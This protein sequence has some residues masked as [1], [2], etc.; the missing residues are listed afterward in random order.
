MPLSAPIHS[1][2]RKARLLSRAD[3]IP[4]SQALNH[5]AEKEGFGS[6]SLLLARRPAVA[7]APAGAVFADLVPGDLLL[8]GARPGQGKTLMSLRLM[9]EAVRAGRRA[10]FFTLEYTGED[11]I[12]RL[13]AIGA[14]WTQFDGLFEFDNSDGINADYIIARLES[15]PRG[16]LVVIDYLQILDQRRDSPELMVQ[17]KTLQ[18]FARARGMIIA[19][20]SQ[21]DRS[22]DP[23]V[24]PFPDL[25]D[26]R[27][28]NPLDL[29]LFS[30]TCFINR[31]AVH[32][33]GAG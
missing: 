7:S 23:S 16:T 10:I 13:R 32:F 22:Y 26:V 24:K 3:N 8:V 2:K 25:S 5:V 33:S 14:D 9:V 6:W 29:A 31:G 20:S 4:L 27:L 19:F 1:L 11:I 15:L 21:I 17:V 18:S 12:G 28:P 30:K